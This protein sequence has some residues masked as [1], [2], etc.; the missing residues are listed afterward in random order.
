MP[1]GTNT[2]VLGVTN[3]TDLSYEQFAATYLMKESALPE[4]AQILNSKCA[5][6]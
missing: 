2:Y 1:Q 6:V 3:F 5:S 4:T